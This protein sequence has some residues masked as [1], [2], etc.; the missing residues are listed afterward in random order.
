MKNHNENLLLNFYQ[1]LKS[2]S[3]AMEGQLWKKLTKEEK[4]ELLTAFEESKEEYNLISH[5]EM[6]KK[7]KKWL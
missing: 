5:E 2:R 6:K 3:T 7:H 1:L 4:D